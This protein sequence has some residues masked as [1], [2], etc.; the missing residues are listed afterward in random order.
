MKTF[1]AFLSTLAALALELT[2][3]GA[4]LRF[5]QPEGEPIRKTYS[6]FS[7]VPY[8][9]ANFFPLLTA[10]LTCLLLFYFVIAFL[11]KKQKAENTCFYLAIVGAIF[12]FL[13][14]LQGF[15]NYS[16]TGFGI[17]VLLSLAVVLLWKIERLR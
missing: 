13:P 10:I 14:L 1:L 2:P 5:A 7:L 8:G 3:W 11:T 6:Y 12:S 4:V 16:L 15:G 9:Y 17:S